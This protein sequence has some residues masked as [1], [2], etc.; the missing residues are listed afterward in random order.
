MTAYAPHVY[1]K[2]DVVNRAALLDAG[3]NPADLDA[4]GLADDAEIPVIS[5]Y[6]AA[7]LGGAIL[8]IKVAGR[9]RMIG[10]ARLPLV[11]LQGVGDLDGTP[12]GKVKPGDRLAWNYGYVTIV[13]AVRPVSAKFVEIDQDG[14]GQFA[15]Q[16]STRRLKADRLVAVVTRE[17]AGV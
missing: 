16:S 2:G 17:W 14:T 5:A 3:A 6:D 8:G 4:L 1:R 9:T 10:I 13:T 12:A 7:H 11:H 15:G